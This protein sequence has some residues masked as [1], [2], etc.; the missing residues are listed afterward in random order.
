M[1]VTLSKAKVMDLEQSIRTVGMVT[2]DETRTQSH[3]YKV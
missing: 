3:S 1:G 2:A